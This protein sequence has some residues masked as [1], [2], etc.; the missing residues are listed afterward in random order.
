[1][2]ASGVLLMKFMAYTLKIIINTKLKNRLNQD[3]FNC[4]CFPICLNQI[5]VMGY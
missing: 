4:S 2:I 3:F 1:M 5:T